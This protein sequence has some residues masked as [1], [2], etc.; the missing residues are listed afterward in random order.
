MQV[1]CCGS[2]IYYCGSLSICIFQA[3]YM[4]RSSL[5]FHLFAVVA[6]VVCTFP[7]LS[8][9]PFVS[10]HTKTETRNLIDTPKSH[11]FAFTFVHSY[12]NLCGFFA[13]FFC[14]K[15][16]TCCL[17]LCAKREKERGREEREKRDR[18]WGREKVCM[19]GI[20]AS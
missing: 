7:S 4:L 12:E 17:S 16:K 14:R 20:V 9:P 11:A 5:G 18:E 8:H 6:L 2:L 15:L 13:I 1:V 19:P 10:Q 3:F